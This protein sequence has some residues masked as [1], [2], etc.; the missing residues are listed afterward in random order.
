M[1][2]KGKA[3]TMDSIDGAKLDPEFKHDV[4]RHPG[5][6]NITLC[7]S[8]RTGPAGK[9]LLDVLPAGQFCYLELEIGIK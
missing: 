3:W 4:A 2:G 7:Y 5:G 8:C 6:E 1:T 9:T